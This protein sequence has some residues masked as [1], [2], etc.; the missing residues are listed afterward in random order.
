M[1]SNLSG[2]TY[3]EWDREQ[4]DFRPVQLPTSIPSPPD[5]DGPTWWHAVSDHHE[6]PVQSDDGV[7]HLG[8]Y[9]S[10]KFRSGVQ[11]GMGAPS[12]GIFEIEFPSRLKVLPQEHLE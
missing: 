12:R 2:V 8:D 7:T 1:G 11:E 10:A 4:D 9:H 5:P 3:V 6:V